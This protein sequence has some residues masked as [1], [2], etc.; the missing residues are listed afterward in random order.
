METLD[1]RGF[2]A[3]TIYDGL[4]LFVQWYNVL[5][6][7]GMKTMVSYV[8][9]E[10]STDS[11]VKKHVLPS[12]SCPKPANTTKEY[13]QPIYYKRT[14]KNTHLSSRW[15]MPRSWCAAT[16]RAINR[17]FVSRS[18]DQRSGR[19]K[20][21]GRPWRGTRRQRRRER[22]HTGSMLRYG[23]ERASMRV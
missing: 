20:W 15:R 12:S 23:S 17:W 21:R 1:S 14:Q 22:S 9:K 11:F 19:R 13:S 3:A 5:P 2:N 6:I 7:R 4:N 10:F 16:S 8:K 18:R